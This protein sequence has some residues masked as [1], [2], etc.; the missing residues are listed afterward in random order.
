[1]IREMMTTAPGP[2][3]RAEYAA[4][5]L[6]LRKAGRQAAKSLRRMDAHRF[7][8]G[9][10]E[11]RLREAKDAISKA[12]KKADPCDPDIKWLVDNHRIIRTALKEIRASMRSFRHQPVVKAESSAE[13]PRAYALVNSY[14]RASIDSFTE[15]GLGAFAIG[16]Q[17]LQELEMGEVWALKPALQ[18]ALVERIAQSA[19]NSP[20]SL[21][22]LITSLRVAGE[23]EWKELFESISIVDRVLARDPAGAYSK[24]DY[25]TRAGTTTAT[26]SENCQNTRDTRNGKSPKRHWNWRKRLTNIRMNGRAVKGLRMSASGL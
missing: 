11:K 9:V 6:R 22:V 10:L 23:S 25:I 19:T 3:P 20:A 8:F 2:A 24:M 16:F 1:M 17:E 13:L 4:D 21:A 15:D 18:L 12:V 5:L 14:L 7:H 26:P